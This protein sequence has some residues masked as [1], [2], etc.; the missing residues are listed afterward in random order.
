MQNVITFL[1]HNVMTQNVT[2][3][4]TRS[5]STKLEIYSKN[6]HGM[7]I[8]ADYWWEWSGAAEL[9]GGGVITEN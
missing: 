5:Q 3:I 8:P 1:T 6:A 4:C 9:G 2:K 7:C